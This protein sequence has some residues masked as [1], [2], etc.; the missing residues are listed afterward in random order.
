MSILLDGKKASAE[1][2]A[3][4]VEKVKTLGFVPKLCILQLGDLPESNAYIGQKIKMGEKIGAKVEHIKFPV[5]IS[6]EKII[7]EIE[8]LNSDKNVN[9]IIVQLPI[10]EKLSKDKILSAIDSNKDVDG[11]G[12][13]NQKKLLDGSKGF[14][15]ATAKGVMD[16]LDFYGIEIEGKKAVVVGRSMLVGKP[17]ALELLRRNATVT[18]CHRKT[19]ELSQE[20]KS[21]VILVSAAGKA[22]LIGKNEVA[23]GQI[24]VDVG[25]NVMDGTKLEDEIPKKKMVGDVNFEEVKDIVA[26]I[27]PVPGGVGPMTVVSLFENLIEACEIQNKIFNN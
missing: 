8:R 9:G 1:K 11:L 14:V 25:I 27:S 21:A 12:T 18:V 20:T 6:E 15:P 26:A 13:L 2:A 7:A 19:A 22:N 3:V 24:V 23:P 17:I 4:L 16:L 5:D 10:P